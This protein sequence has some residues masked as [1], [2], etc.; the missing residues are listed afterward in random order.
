MVIVL[1]IL[2]SL[3]IALGAAWVLGSPRQQPDRAA[4]ACWRAFA[5]RLDLNYDPGGLLKGP[6]ITGTVATMTL[7]MDTLYQVRDGRKTV[8]T[9]VTMY[10]EAASRAWTRQ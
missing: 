2:A 6:V 9:R 1:A 7:Q 4:E 3:G 5:D 10:N 8:V